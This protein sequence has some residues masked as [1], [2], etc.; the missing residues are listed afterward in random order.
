M[1]NKLGVKTT[2]PRL[3][4]NAVAFCVVSSGTR[5]KL[6]KRGDEL[7]QG[8][9]HVA[10]KRTLKVMK[11]L[12]SGIPIMSSTWISECLR[13][14]KVIDPVEPYVINT[15]PTKGPG[16][17]EKD[18]LGGGSY[19]AVALAAANMEMGDDKKVRI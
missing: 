3:F 12:A 8:S 14:G 7:E 5:P 9:P 2:Q 1:L 13:Q 19:A 18:E 16:L 10:A 6:G 4:S 17:R 11:A 15:I